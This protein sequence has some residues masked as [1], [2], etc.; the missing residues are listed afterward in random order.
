LDV[1]L[2]LDDREVVRLECDE[3]GRKY[4]RVVIFATR[5]G[6]AYAVVSAVCHGHGDNEVWLD[7]TFGSWL[8]PFSDHVTMSC[9]VSPEGAGLVDPLVASRGEAEYY[10]ARLSREAALEHPKLPELWRLVDQ[11]VVD[12][13]QVSWALNGGTD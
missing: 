13:P 12:I 5:D 8:E 1:I 11:V 7:A 4:D 2:G 10:G 6:D 3:C 9:S